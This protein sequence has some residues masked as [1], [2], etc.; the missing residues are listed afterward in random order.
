M[1]RAAVPGRAAPH[2]PPRYLP[3]PFPPGVRPIDSRTHWQKTIRWTLGLLALWALAGLG[4][5]IL[6]A[7]ALNGTGILGAIPLG[8]WFAQQGSILVFVAIVFVYALVMNRLDAKWRGS[9]PR[10]DAGN[11][12]PPPRSADSPPPPAE[13][14]A[15]P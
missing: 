10:T 15:Q 2:P 1:I 14:E 7:D 8:F 6:F 12:A 5:G 9:N 13:K 4:C 11:A 3:R